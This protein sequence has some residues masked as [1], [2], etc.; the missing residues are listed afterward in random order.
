VVT[1]YDVVMGADRKYGE[2]DAVCIKGEGF[3]EGKVVEIVCRRRVI[4]DKTSKGDALLYKINWARLI[5]DESHKFCNAKTKTYKAV[6]ALGAKCRWV[7]SGTIIRNK[8]TDL[9]ALLRFIGY[10]RCPT[11]KMWNERIYAQHKLDKVVLKMDY[12]DAKI[13]LP[14]RTN[15]DVPYTF[16]ENEQKAYDVVKARVVKAYNGMMLGN[17]ATGFMHVLVLFTRPHLITPEAKRHYKQTDSPVDEQAEKELN[18][19][20]Q[21]LHNWIHDREGTA[22][23]KSA[24]MQK[25][26]EIIRGIPANEKI[27]IFSIFTSALDIAEQSIEE[28]FGSVPGDLIDNG[29]GDEGVDQLEAELAGLNLEGQKGHPG[30]PRGEQEPGRADDRPE[31]VGEERQIPFTVAML[32]GETKHRD[33][34]IGIFKEDPKCRILMSTYKIG[35]EGHQLT[36]AQHVI[37]LEPWWTKTVMDQAATRVHR[38]GQDKECHIYNLYAQDSIEDTMV[39]TICANKVAIRDRFFGGGETGGGKSAPVLGKAMMGRILG[40]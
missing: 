38:Y 34:V 31:G 19:A 9:W 7:M 40:M 4:E 3:F 16:S 2:S 32:T 37:C 29:V 23:I 33:R 22:G 27:I 6:M 35:G 26:V 30:S 24:K 1:T 25:M 39:L 5:T 18:D 17:T 10:N 36:T 21:G 14:K 8:D 15:H 28:A 11:A 12:K 13:E 20:T